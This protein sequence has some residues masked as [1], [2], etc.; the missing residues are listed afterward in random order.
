MNFRKNIMALVA[1]VLLVGGASDALAKMDLEIKLTEPRWSFLLDNLPAASVDA[2]IKSNEGSFARKLQPML[3][4]QNY[5]AVLEAFASRPLADDS[6]ALNVLRGQVSLQQ[7][8]YHQAVK[9]FDAALLKAPDLASAHQSIS[10]AY[11]QQKQYAMAQK[12]LA[13]CIELGVADAQVFGQLA[14]VNLQSA[15]PAS[16]VWGY[17]QALF[18]QPDKEQWQRGLLYALQGAKAYTQAQGL[19]EELLLSHGSDADL[20]LQRSQLALQS[21]DYPNALS[22]LEVAIRLGAKAPEHHIVAAKLHLEHGSVDKSVQLLGNNLSELKHSE[23]AQLVAANEQVVA[24]L[25]QQEYWAQAQTLLS[26]S[27]DIRT[28]LSS[29]ENA[30]L[31]MYQAKIE[32]HKGQTQKAQQWLQK[33]I[34]E[35][36]SE[37]EALLSL[38]DLYRA[39]SRL[40]QAEQLYV[41]AQALEPFSER[42]LLGQAQLEINRKDYRRAV[43]LLRK[44]LAKNPQRSDIRAN[45]QALDQLL[46]QAS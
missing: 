10:L 6:A 22:S 26:R 3:S 20:W 19:L 41:R 23:R 44:V 15:H 4:A 24:W 18:L 34:A 39:D 46:L 43:G 30:R 5:S 16:A 1:T 13:R 37:G 36:P 17:Q 45:I 11:M 40:D 32:L 28:Q 29:A 38:A 9:A 27:N 35:N 7:K 42:A 2:Q 12:H 25:I 21:K 31:N 8:K 14:Y 33:A